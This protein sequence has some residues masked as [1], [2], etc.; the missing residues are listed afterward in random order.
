MKSGQFNI[1]DIVTNMLSRV[2]DC[3]EPMEGNARGKLDAVKE[4][5]L[6]ANTPVAAD[7]SAAVEGRNVVECL[8][9]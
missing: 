8:A 2:Q 6:G 1:V 9:S 4:H 5:S 7:E 3:R